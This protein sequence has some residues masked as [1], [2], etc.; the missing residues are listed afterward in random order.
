MGGR[1]RTC[2]DR[3]PN[4]GAT[5][6]RAAGR[7][8]SL[9]RARQVLLLLP[10]LGC[11]PPQAAPGA[12]EVALPPRAVA[13]APSPETARVA[14]RAEPPSEPAF[15]PPGGDDAP[16]QRIGPE[17]EVR[18]FT[19]QDQDSLRLGL[20]RVQPRLRACY[21]HALESSPALTGRLAV[22]LQVADDGTVK[23]T[24]TSATIPADV[25]AC[26]VAALR[27]VRLPSGHG[28]VSLRVP[29]VFSN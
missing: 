18:P 13:P 2:S 10:L 3:A 27:A 5:Q 15:A 20:R 16:V 7:G 21:A 24:V 4:E 6:A 29:L 8:R 9:V 17:P 12:Q 28:G 26:V 11:A 22:E 25:S 14:A 1:W 23:V 19:D